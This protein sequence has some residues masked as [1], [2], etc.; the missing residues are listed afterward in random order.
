MAQGKKKLTIIN[1]LD[2]LYATKERA[3]KELNLTEFEVKNMEFIRKDN[4]GKISYVGKFK[5]H[6]AKFEDKHVVMMLPE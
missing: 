4:T 5:L 3:L 6:I 2:E 1:L